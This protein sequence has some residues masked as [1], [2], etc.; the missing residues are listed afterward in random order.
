[1]KITNFSFK[2]ILYVLDNET[3]K[4]ARKKLQAF[5]LVKEGSK[6]SAIAEKFEIHTNT[7]YAWIK[8]I[9]TE[10]LENLK[11]KPGRGLNSK[12]TKEQY[13][14]LEKV[15]SVPIP[16]EDGYSRGWQSKD[17]Y[18]HI[19]NNYNISYSIR[20]IQEILNLVGF[21]KIVCRPRNKRRNESLTQEFL[22]ITKKNEIYWVKNT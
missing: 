11:I 22:E 7:L 15:I 20:R 17:V 2:D 12:L 6:I 13:L 8:Q 4:F 14:D 16:T 18:Q 9:K 10:G 19:L 5:L 3:D 21:S 1:M